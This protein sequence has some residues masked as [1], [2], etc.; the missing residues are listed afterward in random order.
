[1][2][3]K[4][5]IATLGYERIY[6]AAANAVARAAPSPYFLSRDWFDRIVREFSHIQAQPFQDYS[7]EGMEQLARNRVGFLR[8]K[9]GGMPARV[10]EVGA[11]AGYVLKR[12]RE[13]GSREAVS[14]DIVDQLWPEVKASGVELRL[15]SAE[16][17]GGMGD[18]SFD[19]VFS[20]GSLEHIPDPRAVFRECCRILAPGGYLYLD[21]GP[22]YYSS[23]GYHHQATL[24]APYLHLLFPETWIH[25]L[26]RER[27]GRDYQGFLPWVNGEPLATYDFCLKPPPMGFLLDYLEVGRDWFSLDIVRRFPSI[28]RA[29]GV[30]FENFVVDCIRYGI[31]RSG[32][33]A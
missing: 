23:W 14:M 4:E 13:E 17:M 7:R 16:D 25:D 6:R 8:E 10:L 20:Y 15:S 21:F 33:I 18:G 30:P 29:K 5:K 27:R 9:F 1:M 3:I 12:F 22:L 24:R 31:R 11:G 2:K 19:L 26:C 32:S 28:F